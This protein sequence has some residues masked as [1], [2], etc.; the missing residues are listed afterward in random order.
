MQAVAGAEAAADEDT[1][2]KCARISQVTVEVTLGDL[3]EEDSDV[4]LCSAD[5]KLSLNTRIAKSLVRKAGDALRQECA[6][7]ETRRAMAAEGLA[8]TSGGQLRAKHVL[9][10]LLPAD[11]EELHQAISKVCFFSKCCINDMR[12]FEFHCLFRQ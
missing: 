1:I 4:L 3:A 9:H 6:S 11:A 12:A 2:R 5:A 7:A 8:C 10:V